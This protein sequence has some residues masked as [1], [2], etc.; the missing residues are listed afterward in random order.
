MAT[1]DRLSAVSRLM[2]VQDDFPAL[3]TRL[4]PVIDDLLRTERN[5]HA[6]AATPATPT[7]APQRDRNG[8]ANA[9]PAVQLD[10][11]ADAPV[12]RD[13]NGRVH[14]GGKPRN[15]NA[16]PA[17]IRKNTVKSRYAA[18]PIKAPQRKERYS[19]YEVAVI[20][21]RSP[22]TVG[23]WCRMGQMKADRFI[24]VG[25]GNAP[26][27]ITHAE[28]ERYKAVGLRDVNPGRNQG[29]PVPTLPSQGKAP[30][31]KEGKGKS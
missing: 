11:I 17:Q 14:R 29:P 9:K 8:K 6:S 12:K 24:P 15:P 25:G 19:I 27:S 3:A 21:G 18:Q 5:G 31:R 2:S 4:R 26:W 13:R 22:W 20:V 28:V 10:R 30:K 7:T 1:H 23:E 16:T